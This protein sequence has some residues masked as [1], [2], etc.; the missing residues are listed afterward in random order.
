[1]QILIKQNSDYD[2]IANIKNK[3]TEKTQVEYRVIGIRGWILI[4]G[5]S[6]LDRQYFIFCRINI[7]SFIHL[8]NT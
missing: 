2:N 8:T 1:M 6:E 4:H 7:R 5:L 3:F